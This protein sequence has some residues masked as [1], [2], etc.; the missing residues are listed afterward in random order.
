MSKKHINNIKELCEYMWY[1]EEKYDLL[2]LEINGVH[3]WAAYR[4]DIYYE[5]GK[6]FNV[7]DSNHSMKLSKK[8]KIINFFR[9]IK[10][11]FNNLHKIK[12]K[13]I[14]VIIFSHNRSKIIENEHRDPYSYFIKKDLKQKNIKFIEYEFPYKGSYIRKKEPTKKYLDKILILRNI[15]NLFIKINLDNKTKKKIDSLNKELNI[16]TCYKFD[17]KKF[18][19]SNVK[20]FIITYNFYIN[21]LQKISPKKIFVV[22]SYGKGE[23]IKAAKELNIKVIELQHG[24]FS[25]YHL[26]Y[27]FPNTKN[28]TYFP[29]E[30]YVWNS[31]W[32]NII[33]LPINKDNVIIHPFKYLNNEKEKYLLNPKNKNSLIIFGQGGITDKI[34]ERIIQRIDTI[35]KYDVT[36]KLHPNEYHMLNRYD[37]L[38]YLKEK[39]NFKIVTDINIY[40]YLS[41]SEYQGGVF[42]TVLYEGLEF[43]CKTI[44]FNLP[45]IEYMDEFIKKYKP[46]II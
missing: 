14:D 24:T 45:G 26:G 11:Y 5:I 28:N 44:L 6:V 43:N 21:E 33:K 22:V 29:D 41:L 40:E 42:S 18:L 36:F 7:F 39:Y 20:K 13:N 27:S 31:Y 16:A 17:I 3:P 15:K 23:L 8:D 37:K 2:N 38:N 34:A 46:I 9:L 19:I 32:K 1:L 4:M 30:L 12:S 10:H 25:K 35:K